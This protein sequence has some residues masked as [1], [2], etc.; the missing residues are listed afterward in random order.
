[1]P[2][3]S[4]TPSERLAELRSQIEELDQAIVRLVARRRDLAR[5]IGAA[6]RAAGLPAVDPDREHAVLER[7]TAVARAEGMPDREIR[8]LYELLIEMSRT[9]QNAER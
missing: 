2:P 1:V 9:A 4:P 6:Q 3:D 7:V 5:D 8:R